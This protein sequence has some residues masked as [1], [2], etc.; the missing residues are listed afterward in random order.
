MRACYPNGSRS[1]MGMPPEE[2]ARLARRFRRKAVF[3]DACLALG[4][5]FA[6]L[7][8][9]F[10]DFPL[11]WPMFCAVIPLLAAAAAGIVLTYR[12]CPFCGR[13]FRRRDWTMG[14]F[15]WRFFQCPECDFTPDW[16]GKNQ[17]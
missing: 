9:T 3:T 15:L 2:K 5:A 17:A 10:Q 1:D 8:L 11:A 13:Y 7:S 12:R 14:P 6:I 16:S 4:L